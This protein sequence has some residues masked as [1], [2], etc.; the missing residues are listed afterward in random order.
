MWSIHTMGYDSALKRKEILT[1]ATA[2]MNLEDMR[3]SEIS[4]SQKDKHHPR[5]PLIN[6]TWS[7]PAH[8][9]PARIPDPPSQEL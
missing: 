9:S 5:W 4:Q 1:P 7:R 3:L 2:W 6:A 8:L